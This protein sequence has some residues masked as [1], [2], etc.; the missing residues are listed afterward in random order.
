MAPLLAAGVSFVAVMIRVT[1]VV[2]VAVTGIVISDDLTEPVL[3]TCPAVASAAV[4]IC[5]PVSTQVA[6]GAKVAQVF[7]AGVSLAS[8]TTTLVC[9]T[10]PELV[11]VTVKAKVSPT[12]NVPV[13][14]LSV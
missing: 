4:T 14:S 12:V 9:V 6:A 11:A 2:T 5:A 1:G 10:V 13:A 3:A 7:E 8:E